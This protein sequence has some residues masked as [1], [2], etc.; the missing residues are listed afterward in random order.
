MTGEIHYSGF[1]LST[2]ATDGRSLL[3]PEMLIARGWL[4]P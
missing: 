4:D 3:N 1:T 2:R